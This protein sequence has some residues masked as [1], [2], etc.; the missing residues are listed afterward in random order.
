MEEKKEKKEAGLKK[1]LSLFELVLAGVGVILGAGIYALIGVASGIAGNAIWLSFLI[2]AV[3]ALITGLSYAELSSIFRKD[4]GEYD[5]VKHAFNKKL[6]FWIGIMVVFAG[7]VTSA[8]VA[9]GFGNY[10]SAL[11]KTPVVYIAILLTILLSLLNYY[12]IKQS[13]WFNSISTFVEVLGLLIIIALGIKYFGNVNY[14][15]MPQGFN[16]VLIATALIFFAFLGFDNIVKLAEETKDPKRMMPKGVILSIIISSIIYILVAISAVSILG[17]QSLGASKAPLADVASRV[18]GQGA[19]LVLAI[20]ALFSTSNTVLV[21]LVT[22]S[23]M[24]YGMAEERSLPKPLAIVDPKTRTPWISIFLVM[25]ITILFILIG[26]I[27]IVA[28]IANLS[29][30]I[31]FAF[32][33]L[34][35]IALRYKKPYLDRPFKVPLNF[36]NFNL[37]AFLGFLFNLFMIYYV[38]VGF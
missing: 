12:G 17:W 16:G 7:I 29:L 38:I 31:T 8:T 18:F 30:F 9:L 35:L 3:I 4:A 20:I 11:F 2:G 34:S 13:S 28:G 1:E 23:R 37:L 33:N 36:G 10:F 22:T 21:S 6:A 15:E 27:K 24:I 5:Y 25:I 26:D 19:F 32:V 14:F